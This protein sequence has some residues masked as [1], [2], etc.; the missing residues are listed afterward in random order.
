M[1]RLAGRIM[2]LWGLPRAAVAFLAGAIGALALPPFSFFAALFLSFTLF[3]WLMDGSTGSPGGAVFGRF[4]STF[5]LGW[6]F[7]FGYFVA[8][9]WWLG[10]ALLVEGDEFAWALPLAVLGLPACLALFYGLATAIA[11]IFWSDGLGR[12]AALA[13]GFGLAE[14][15]RGFVVTGFPWNAVGYGAMPIPLMMQSAAFEI[16]ARF[17]TARDDGGRPRQVQP[18][19]E[20]AA[21]APL[22]EG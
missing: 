19:R 4:R 2:L 14:W 11:G 1:G 12:I 3:V 16:K 9:L 6:F 22:T 17:P 13:F 7:G 8:G 10:N 20:A 15:F 21:K 18:I 5:S